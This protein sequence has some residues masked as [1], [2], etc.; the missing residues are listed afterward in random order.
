M[1]IEGLGGST[2]QALSGVTVQGAKGTTGVDAPMV[3]PARIAEIREQGRQVVDQRPLANLGPKVSTL[4]GDLTASIDSWKGAAP[5]RTMPKTVGVLMPPSGSMVQLDGKMVEHEIKA[6]RG[7]QREQAVRDMPARL[8]ERVNNGFRLFRGISDGSVTG[9]ATREDVR[10]LMTFL[11]AKAREKGSSFSE[12]AFNL[13]DPGH[14]LRNFLDSCSGEVYQRPSSHIPA[15]R[16]ATGGA[17]RG[18]DMHGEPSL[19]FGQAT[20]LYGS[21]NRGVAD[22]PEDRLFLKTESHG[23]RL[24]AFKAQNVDAQGPANRPMR[25][26]RDLGQTLGHAMGFART[27]LRGLSGGRLFANAPDSRKERLPEDLKRDYKALITRF[28]RSGDQLSAGI[29]K[30]DDPLSKS[31][32]VR[33]M[34]ENLESALENVELTDAD[35]RQALQG[36]LDGIKARYDHVDVR[37]GDEVVFDAGELNGTDKAAL[38]KGQMRDAV[39]ELLAVDTG[40]GVPREAVAGF[41]DRMARLSASMERSHD[42]DAFSRT[43]LDVVDELTRGLGRDQKDQLGTILSSDGCKQYFAGVDQVISD[44]IELLGETLDDRGVGT[45]T[46]CAMKTVDLYSMLCDKLGLEV[47][48]PEA[49]GDGLADAVR[50]MERIGMDANVA[51]YESSDLARQDATDRLAERPLGFQRLS[52]LRPALGRG[53]TVGLVADGLRPAEVDNKALG[54]ALRA[55]LTERL[56]RPE[57]RQS[58]AGGF[59]QAF[60][61]QFT[62]AGVMVDGQTCGGPDAEGSLE[63]QLGEFTRAIGG[64]DK[65]RQAA[66]LFSGDL[67]SEMLATLRQDPGLRPLVD[68]HQSHGGTVLG[69]GTTLLSFLTHGDDLSVHIDYSEQKLGSRT[70]SHQSGVALSLDYTIQGHGEDDAVVRLDDWDVL[71]GTSP[72]QRVSRMDIS[73]LRSVAGPGVSVV[74]DYAHGKVSGTIDQRGIKDSVTESLRAEMG[75][76]ERNTG[77]RGLNHEFVK[78]FFR[79]SVVVDGETYGDASRMEDATARG[80]ERELD[81]FIEAVGGEKRARQLSMVM[82]QNVPGAFFEG[83]LAQVEDTRELF[84]A[85]RMHEGR[86]TGGDTARF[87]ATTREDGTVSVRLDYAQQ[88]GEDDEQHVE[89]GFRGQLDYTLSGLGTDTPHLELDDLFLVV[90]SNQR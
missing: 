65:A 3:N 66:K 9:P 31:Q 52:D 85:Y 18:L 22:M 1:G 27:V 68:Q 82:Y 55:A 16:D 73:D 43:M 26:L 29:L 33:T 84:I 89:M 10:D 20:V 50:T 62:R 87:Y 28:E 44:S 70:E 11:T 81:R 90:G 77:Y 74:G 51:Y 41:G 24:T 57:R 49:G 48:L 36:I 46:S 61:S 78:D 60:V 63:E 14:K 80:R 76:T 39:R 17:H 54:L 19:P 30:L 8:Q 79:R 21:M 5:A 13:P 72:D 7:G 25:F 71:F 56:G 37:I 75:R 35:D 40:K 53:F 88:K 86:Y 2:L 6:L 34:V 32:G 38:A 64:G 45:A 83:G 4:R 58:V 69:S 47:T 12:G 23:C 59:P 15:F 67:G 42:R